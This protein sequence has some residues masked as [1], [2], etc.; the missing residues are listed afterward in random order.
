M[1]RHPSACRRRGN[2]I[3]QE[4]VNGTRAI[5]QGIIDCYF[6]DEDG[7]VLIDYKN[8]YIGRMDD[9]R[10]IAERYKGQVKIYKKALELACG[11]TVKEAYLYLFNLKKFIPLEIQ[12]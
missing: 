4:E 8:S 6:E 2:F 3:L 7:L 12:K 5:V 11:K 10:K 9:E 1:R